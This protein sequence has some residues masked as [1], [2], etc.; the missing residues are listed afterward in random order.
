M[1]FTVRDSLAINV[2]MLIHPIDAIRQWQAG[3]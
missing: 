1:V 2:V 3:G